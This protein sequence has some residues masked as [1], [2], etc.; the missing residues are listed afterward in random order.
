MGQIGYVMLGTNDLTRATSFYDG[1]LAPLGAKRFIG[2]ERGASWTFGPASTSISVV[3]PHHGRL[4]TCWQR[5]H[6][7]HRCYQSKRG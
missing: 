2:S 5:R 4:A 6:G 1:L 7:C 3:K